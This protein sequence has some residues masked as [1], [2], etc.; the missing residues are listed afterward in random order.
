MILWLYPFIFREVNLTNADKEY[1]QEYEGGPTINVKQE[2]QKTNNSYRGSYS[3]PGNAY[4]QG[5]PYS[6]EIFSMTN[7]WFNFQKNITKSH[8]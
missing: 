3:R 6:D 7:H 4:C 1:K 8:T 2:D 5:K